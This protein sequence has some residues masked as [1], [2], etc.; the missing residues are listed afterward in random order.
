MAADKTEIQIKAAEKRLDAIER[1]IE[2]LKK[3]SNSNDAGAQIKALTNK[4]DALTSRI[5]TMAATVKELGVQMVLKKDLKTATKLEADDKD[6]EYKAREMR[7]EAEAK[8]RLDKE[9][10]AR[11]TEMKEQK[12]MI[13]KMVSE[14]VLNARFM[15]LEAEY[16]TKIKVLEAQIAA[17]R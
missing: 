14:Q 6:R 11:T 13:D 5:D 1:S 17:K 3:D 12:T 10:A 16:G 7:A 15:K 8:S 9:T 2:T 4:F